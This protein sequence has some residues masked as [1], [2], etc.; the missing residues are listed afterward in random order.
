M[1]NAMPLVTAGSL[2]IVVTLA[3][4]GLLW[5]PLFRLLVDL[6]GN[7]E[8]AIFWR[9]LSAIFLVLVPITALMLARDEFP[10][11][12]YAIAVVDQLRWA[13]AGLIIALFLIAL[14]VSAFIPHPSRATVAVNRDQVDELNRLLIKVDEIR[15]REIVRQADREQRVG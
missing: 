13:L 10:N 9:N 11:A 2:T 8:R 12:N 1:T 15:A 5:L 6:C 14:G 7:Q 4:I 3:V